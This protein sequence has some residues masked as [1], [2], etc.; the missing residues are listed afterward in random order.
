MLGAA[1]ARG[2]DGRPVP[3]RLGPLPPIGH[4]RA[5]RNSKT[6]QRRRKRTAVEISRRATSRAC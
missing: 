5:L 2:A 3:I 4:A 1:A 6:T